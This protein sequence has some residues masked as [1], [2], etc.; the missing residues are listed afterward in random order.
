MKNEELNRIENNNSGE[1]PKTSRIIIR[2]KN[3]KNADKVLR[4]TK[5]IMKSISKYAYTNT[6]P[7]DDEW[8]D[9]LPK[10]FV[11]GMTLKSSTDR[12]KDDNLWHYESW[13]DNMRM[14]AWVWWS[15]KKSGDDLEFVLETL[16]IPYL[17][18]GF[19]Y[20]LYS[21]GVPIE[22]IISVDDID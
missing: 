4:N 19:L 12:D 15:S 10:W 14:R 8:K 5:E 11:E 7:N 20:I 17:F 22:N 13:I 18:E 1:E 2:A 9:I 6:W 3:V 21:Q 16:S